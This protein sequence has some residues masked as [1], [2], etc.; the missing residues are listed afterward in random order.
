MNTVWLPAA[1]TVSGSA[2]RPADT[3]PT[4]AWKSRFWTTNTGSIYDVVPARTGYQKPAGQWNEEEIVADGSHIRVTLNGAVII[5]FDLNLVREP[6]VLKKHPGLRRSGG[7][8]GFL[9]HKT[10]VDFRNIRIKTLP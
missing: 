4:T 5:D 8:V 7:Y 6:A 1:T 2:C 9:G 3:P 10:R